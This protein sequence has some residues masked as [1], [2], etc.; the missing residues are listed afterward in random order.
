[1]QLRQDE[2]RRGWARKGHGQKDGQVIGMVKEATKEGTWEGTIGGVR[3]G[4]GRGQG[5]T[6]EW[7]EREMG[8]D[9]EVT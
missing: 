6:W 3:E 8:G 1:M 5:G 7:L 4:N 2:D 9:R